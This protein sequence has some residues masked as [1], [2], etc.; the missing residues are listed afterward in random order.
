MAR[1]LPITTTGD[2]RRDRGYSFGELLV[3]VVLIGVLAAIVTATVR[4]VT[5]E[6]ADSGCR[7]DARQVAMAATSYLEVTRTE[8]IP[9][10]GHDGD[11]FERTLVEAGYLRAPSEFYELDADGAL[12]PQEDSP[13]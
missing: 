5:A 6:A 12:V 2:D 3:T 10:T 13:C 8:L 9:A 1:H 7:V 4:N 11:R